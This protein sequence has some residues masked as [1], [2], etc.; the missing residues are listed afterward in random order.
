[1]SEWD[2][3]PGET[4]HQF[5]A[6]TTYR[7]LGPERTLLKTHEALTGIRAKKV[8][9]SI[10]LWSSKFRWIERVNAWDQF[11]SATR[12]NAVQL[13]ERKNGDQIAALRLAHK[14]NES[15][16]SAAMWEKAMQILALPLTTQKTKESRD[17]KT[18]VTIHKPIKCNI[19][20]VAILAVA[21]SKIGRNGLD[22]KDDESDVKP[23]EFREMMFKT[24]RQFAEAVPAGAVPVLPKD[25]NAPPP[26][27]LPADM[28]NAYTNHNGNGNGHIIH[29]MRPPGE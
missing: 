26:L 1:M 14:R 10:A 17:G 9:G 24:D 19:N 25:V 23:T 12:D 13:H 5:R 22:I 27:K 2:R 29:K 3:Q 21:A 18:I 28:I 4:P 16:V 11:L 7:D 6:F 8:P 20:T 15:A